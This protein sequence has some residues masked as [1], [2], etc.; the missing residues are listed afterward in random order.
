VTSWT[1]RKRSGRI[2]AANVIPIVPI[3]NV[4]SFQDA[5]HMLYVAGY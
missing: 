4:S 5:R 3:S 2:N 1:V